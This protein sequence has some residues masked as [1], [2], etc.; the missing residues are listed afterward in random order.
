MSLPQRGRLICKTLTHDINLGFVQISRTA[1]DVGPY[2]Y[3]SY[4][5]HTAKKFAQTRGS[6]SAHARCVHTPNMR[7]L[8]SFCPA[9]KFAQTVGSRDRRAVE[10]CSTERSK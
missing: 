2:V 10:L 4:V 7:R 5:C 9:L 6:R 8:M 1:E 3:K